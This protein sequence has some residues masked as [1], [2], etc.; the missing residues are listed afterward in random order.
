MPSSGKDAAPVAAVMR[1]FDDLRVE[2]SAPLLAVL[3]DRTEADTAAALD[4]LWRAGALTSPT[5]GWYRPTAPWDE[6]PAP[7]EEGPARRRLVEHL[8]TGDLTAR[9]VTAHRPLLLAALAATDA[10]PDLCA[11][12]RRLW[13]TTSGSGLAHDPAWRAALMAAG[14]RAAR[15]WGN[16]AALAV[17]LDRSARV[18][19]AEGD[20][21]VAESQY[22]RALELWHDLADEPHVIA[23]LNALVGLF[24][25]AGRWHRALDAAF[26]LLAEHRR[27]E[28]GAAVAATLGLLGEL[29]VGAG[30]PDAG[31]HYLEQADAAFAEY[32]S[33]EHA[34]LLLVLGR[35]HWS[36]GAFPRARRAFH[37]ALAVL[38]D[39]DDA[40]AEEV[41]RLLRT[42]DGVPLPVT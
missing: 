27:H 38:V 2:L 5:P 36:A 17:L 14:E 15:A 10:D 11:L 33:R 4:T 25:A 41:R 6:L 28:Q 26:E 1:C 12:V 39:A 7:A 23:T 13:D 42:P 20:D 31:T 18:A 8:V 30:R 35:Q 3:L 24:R 37:R 16:R 19:V 40:R 22:V 9:E 29:M 34:E 32:P 21:I